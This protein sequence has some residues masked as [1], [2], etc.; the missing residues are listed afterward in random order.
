M[1]C[2]LP[3]PDDPVGRPPHRRERGGAAPAH[4]GLH[5]AGAARGPRSSTP[6]G[7]LSRPWTFVTYMFV[8]A[9]LLHLLGNMLMLFVFGAAGRERMGGRRSSS[10]ISTAASA[11]RSSRS[12][13]RVHALVQ[14]F[15]GALGRG[16]R[17]RL[18]LRDALARRRAG[19]L[20]DSVPIKARTFVILLV[21]FDAILALPLPARRRQ[22]RARGA[23]GRRALRLSLLPAPGGP[24]AGARAAAARR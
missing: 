18:R 7:A 17:R 8:H 5:L 2:D 9:G 23:P 3:P 16:A 1:Q 12:G 19:R 21:A 14:P 22:H 24:A 13:S 10:T 11:R 20:P 4:D 6:A 15:I